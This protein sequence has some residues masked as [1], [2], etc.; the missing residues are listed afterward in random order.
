M[1]YHKLVTGSGNPEMAQLHPQKSLEASSISYKANPM[2]QY[3]IKCQMISP[4]NNWHNKIQLKI[5]STII[6][7]T[8]TLETKG[9][10]KAIICPEKS[11]AKRNDALTLILLQ[12]PC[13]KSS[14]PSQDKI[15]LQLLE[16]KATQIWIFKPEN[17]NWNLYLGNSSLCS[18]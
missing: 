2:Q 5:R 18:A 9:T 17:P 16:L 4:W 1:W 13:S 8:D 10:S 3:V 7:Y 11:L 12:M 6:L 15:L 14:S